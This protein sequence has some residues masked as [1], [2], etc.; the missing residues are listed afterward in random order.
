[1]LVKFLEVHI[2]AN[3]VGFA[4]MLSDMWRVDAKTWMSAKKNRFWR[5]KFCYDGYKKDARGRRWQILWNG[6]EVFIYDVPSE[7]EVWRG[8]VFFWIRRRDQWKGR[9][10]RFERKGGWK[11]RGWFSYAFLRADKLVF[12]VNRSQVKISFWQRI[13]CE[14]WKCT[15][16]YSLSC[17]WLAGW[18][19]VYGGEWWVE[20]KKSEGN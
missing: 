17:G 1:M 6:L 7:V 4:N 2:V 18:E 14:S 8:G 12:D 10:Q 9:L 19:V 11:K 15:K 16:K 5:R 20:K 13:S 3:E